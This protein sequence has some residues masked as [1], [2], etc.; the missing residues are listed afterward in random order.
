F[1]FFAKESSAQDIVTTQSEMPIANVTKTGDVGLGA[2]LGTPTAL[3]MKLW[4]AEATAVNVNLS[5]QQGDLAIMGDH[6]WHFRKA[7]SA[8]P[9]V[10]TPA[11]FSPYLGVG[12][13]A[14]MSTMGDTK[15]DRPL[16][17]RT[18]NEEGVGVG[19]RI[20]FGVE[21]LPTGQRFGVFGE[22][23]PG[24]IF[25]PTSFSFLQAGVGGRYYF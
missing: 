21:F 10:D 7:F 19:G 1:F 9:T 13:M 15:S 23:A 6:L 18:D 2:I 25:S 3:N 14:I 24:A 8:D 20:P 16:Y 22:I 4:T 12:L 5:Y 17:R 11:V